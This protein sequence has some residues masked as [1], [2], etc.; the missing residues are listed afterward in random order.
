MAAKK[1]QPTKQYKV[2]VKSMVKVGRTWLRPGA[3]NRVSG[4]VL[5]TIMDSVA[6]YNEV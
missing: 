2:T 4:A 3:N 1:I 5:E 6:E